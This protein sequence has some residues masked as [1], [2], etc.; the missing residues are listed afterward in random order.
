MSIQFNP[1]TGNLDFI[2]ISGGGGSGPAVRYIY[3]F[4]N[5]T[6]WGS[7]SGGYYTIIILAGIHNQ[8]LDPQVMVFEQVGLLF[9]YVTVDQLAL[10][11]SGD[12]SIRVPDSPDLR[13][14]GKLIVI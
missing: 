6:D 3:S 1:F 14:T 9:E 7:P 8:G 12:I 2:G 4:N 10:N 5:T 13:F 11:A